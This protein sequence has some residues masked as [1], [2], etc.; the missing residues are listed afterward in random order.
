MERGWIPPTLH[1]E[2]PDPACDLDIVPNR[3]R[4][5]GLRKVLSNSF[6]FGGINACVVLGKP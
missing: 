6:G 4:E 5:A 1:H 3:G 2:T